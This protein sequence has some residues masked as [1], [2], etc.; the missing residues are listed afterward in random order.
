[1]FFMK[2]HPQ[3]L[4]NWVYDNSIWNNCLTFYAVWFYCMP[5]LGLS[6][7]IETKLQTAWFYLILA[8]FST[9]FLN[10]NISV[11]LVAYISWDVGQCMHCNCWL[12]KLWRHKFWNSP[13][14]S[15][16][17]VFVYMTKKSRQKLKY[18]E[19]EKEFLK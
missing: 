1:M 5:S 7:C 3:N 17:T 13:D 6:K 8:S 16:H 9:W 4:L 10:K 14:L 19:N 12:K 2:I 11:C 18:L 15:N